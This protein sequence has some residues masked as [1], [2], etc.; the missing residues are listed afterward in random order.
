MVQTERL[1]MR[2]LLPGDM[3]ERYYDWMHDEDVTKYLEVR[4]N[5]P[6]RSDMEAFIAHHVASPDS[7]LL[8]IFRGGLHI[9]NVKLAL[10][11]WTHGYADLSYFIGDKTYWGRGYAT[12]AVQGVTD[13]ALTELG[14]YRVE[15]GAQAS[16]M[17]TRRVLEK[18]GFVCENRGA[19]PKM[20][21][22]ETETREPQLIYAMVRA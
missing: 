18:A 10:I 22:P 13:W 21:H 16:H 9:G 12:E 11:N 14:L 5:P 4:F 1:F 8:G 2:Q 20:L 3:S 19:L 17:A 15:A 6:T 7:F